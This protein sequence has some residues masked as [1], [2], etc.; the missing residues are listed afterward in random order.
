MLGWGAEVLAQLA[1]NNRISMKKCRRLTAKDGQIPARRSAE[2]VVLPQVQDIV[3][4]VQAMC[5]GE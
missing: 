4:T 2:E 3:S 1:E 5:Q